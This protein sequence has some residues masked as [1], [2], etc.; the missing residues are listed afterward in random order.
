MTYFKDKRYYF[1]LMKPYWSVLDYRA[2]LGHKLNH[3][4]NAKTR[5]RTVV[6]FLRG[7]SG[8]FFF[9]NFQVREKND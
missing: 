7:M 5:Y 9:F 2:T 3:S 6:N 4:F 8:Q 1:N